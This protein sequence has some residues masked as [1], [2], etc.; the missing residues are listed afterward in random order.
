MEIVQELRQ[1][2]MVQ[3]TDF[4]FSY[5]RSKEYIMAKAPMPNHAT[6]TFYKE[7]YATFVALKYSI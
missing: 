7:K 5:N 4:D 2:G 6:F 3:G 1:Q